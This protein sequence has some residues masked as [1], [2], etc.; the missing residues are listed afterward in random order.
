MSLRWGLKKFLY[1][2][3]AIS[4]TGR[5]G[6]T[7]QHHV[8]PEPGLRISLIGSGLEARIGKEWAG[9]PLP[10]VSEH[11]AATPGTVASREGSDMETASMTTCQVR[12]VTGDRIVTPRKASF[13]TLV[14]RVV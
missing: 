14:I 13:R 5:P 4:A 12:P 1:V 3:E 7:A 9:S 8:R 11:L 6:A 10:N 2:F